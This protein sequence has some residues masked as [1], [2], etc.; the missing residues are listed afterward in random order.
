M[1][2]N[3]PGPWQQDKHFIL[4]TIWLQPGILA[5]WRHWLQSH[6]IAE[7]STGAPSQHEGPSCLTRGQVLVE[8]GSMPGKNTQVTVEMTQWFGDNHA[9]EEE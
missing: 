9:G 8:A 7:G 1:P 5:G 3:E 2:E 4:R 6:Y